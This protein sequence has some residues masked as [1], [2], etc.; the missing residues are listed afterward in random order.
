MSTDDDASARRDGPDPMLVAIADCVMGD[1]T[2]GEVDYG[3]ARDWLMDALARGL[4]AL[5][6]PGCRAL[7]GPVVPGATMM[8]G[9]RVPGTS[10]ELDPVQAAFNIG[11][12]VGWPDVHGVQAVAEGGHPADNLGGILAVAD[13]LSRR[14]LAE[15]KSPLTVRDVLTAL[16]KAHRVQAIAA[17]ENAAD[18]VRADRVSTVC[19]ATAGVV[20]AMLGAT[21]EQ[22]LDTVSSACLDGAASYAG[23]RTPWAIGEATSRGVR[24][25]LIA[26]IGERGDPSALGVATRAPDGGVM[27]R[28]RGAEAMAHGLFKIASPR[29]FEDHTVIGASVA[30]HFRSKQAAA[31]RAMFA[32][33]ARLDRM[34]VP[35]FVSA[36]VRN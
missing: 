27:T 4:Q 32:D 11:V 22:V 14:N 31:I 17:P 7:I 8:G 15:D 20:S 2:V 18:R 21:R 29:G 3:T 33:I 25:A 36:L 6:V 26:R 1:Q 24:H 19:V 10:H 16:I 9:A 13:Y 34:P 12:M 23:M 5:K 30:A 28:P 35:E